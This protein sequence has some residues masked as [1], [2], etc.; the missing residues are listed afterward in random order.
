MAGPHD[1]RWLLASLDGAKVSWL[2][3]TETITKLKTIMRQHNTD[4]VEPG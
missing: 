4:G 3:L 2:V 1:F